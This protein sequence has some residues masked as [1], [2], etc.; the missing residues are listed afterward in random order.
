MEL[1]IVPGAALI[2]GRRGDYQET[3]VKQIFSV[4]LLNIFTSVLNHHNGILPNYR[5]W[6]V[7]PWT[8]YNKENETGYSYH[9]M[10]KEVDHGPILLS[11]SI[12]ID[13]KN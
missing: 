10:T 6:L 3:R 13:T 4:E 11:E 8:L 5:G 12:I 7:T 2:S 1:T 9:Y